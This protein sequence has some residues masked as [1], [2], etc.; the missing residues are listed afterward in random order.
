LEESTLSPD[1]ENKNEIHESVA[2]PTE[3]SPVPLRK[4]RHK[5]TAMR[6]STDALTLITLT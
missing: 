2:E 1:I 4:R 3:S 5:S 6:N